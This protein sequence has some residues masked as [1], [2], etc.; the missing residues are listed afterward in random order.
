M[1]MVWVDGQHGRL[2]YTVG[3]INVNTLQGTVRS[4]R[5]S[6]PAGWTNLHAPE[7]CNGPATITSNLVTGYSTSHFGSGFADGLSLACSG[8]TAR[9]NHII[10]PTDVG[11]VVFSRWNNNAWSGRNIV[12]QN[13]TIIAAGQSAYGGVGFDAIGQ[14]GADFTGAVIQD[15]LL[16][17]NPLQHFDSGLF[18]G[19]EPWQPGTGKNGTALGNTTGFLNL[20]THLGIVIDGMENGVVQSN[21]LYTVGVNTGI[22]CPQDGDVSTHFGPHASGSLQTPATNRAVHQC[23]AHLSAPLLRD[24]FKSNPKELQ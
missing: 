15:N 17:T 21:D 6:E 22:P 5:L 24:L 20:Y 19:T 9:Y 16:W 1:E 13:N 14:T 3:A 4:C 12:V 10:D 11:I 7:W 18:V 2:G 8:T 23:V